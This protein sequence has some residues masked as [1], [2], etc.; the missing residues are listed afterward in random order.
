MSVE[1]LLFLCM[2]VLKTEAMPQEV[3]YSRSA[4]CTQLSQLAEEYGHDPVMVIAIAHT[5]SRFDTEAV[6]SAGARGMMQ[7]LPRY[8]CPKTGPCDYTHAGLYAWKRWKERFK[9]TKDS[10]CGYNSG[11]RCKNNHR[12]TW[13]ANLVLRKYRRLKAIK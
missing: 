1:T 7:V 5:E 12:G 8:F 9:K 10:L 13:Y 4:N 6:S 11:K 3:L 2:S